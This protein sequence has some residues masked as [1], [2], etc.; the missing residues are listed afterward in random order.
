MAASGVAEVAHQIITHAPRGTPS[1]TL[2]PMSNANGR[3][4]SWP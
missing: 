1:R 4:T 3:S 2:R